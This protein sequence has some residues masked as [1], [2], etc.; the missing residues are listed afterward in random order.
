LGGSAGNVI[1]KKSE[2]R[3]STVGARDA[4]GEAIAAAVESAVRKALNITEVTN[5]RVLS[6]EE[7]ANYIGLSRR[8]VYN[9][10][11]NRQ[12]RTIKHGKRTMLDIRD[13]DEWI[14]V[15]KA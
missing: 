13:L 3:M 9:M 2:S 1:N 7:A 4:F 10:I 6:A 11:A 14:E 12:L 8:E 15:K 5:R